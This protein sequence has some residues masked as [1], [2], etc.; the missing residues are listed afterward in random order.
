MSLKVNAMQP[1]ENGD[2]L[3]DTEEGCY[4]MSDVKLVS[5]NLK[6][7]SFEEECDFSIPVKGKLSKLTEEEIERC[8][9]YVRALA[10]IRSR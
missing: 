4:I 2:I 10:V 3:L 1:L 5:Q 6:D 8:T 7:V 9:E